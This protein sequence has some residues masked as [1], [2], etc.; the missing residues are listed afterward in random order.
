[1]YLG[2][3]MATF[4]GQV[5]PEFPT[6]NG[7]IDL[8]ISYAGLLYGLEVKS[9]VNAIVYRYA[10]TQAVGDANQLQL[11]EIWLILF[12]ESVNDE[13]RQRYQVRYTDTTTDVVVHP[14][15]VVTG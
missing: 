12:V 11:S 5:Y 1:M 9:F 8:M 10:L 2:Q 7:K 15:F 13:N 4:R 14:L 6:G 3:F